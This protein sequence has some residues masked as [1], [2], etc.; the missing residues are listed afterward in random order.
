MACR[1]TARQ[2]A[3]PPWTARRR[4]AVLWGTGRVASAPKV[5]WAWRVPHS[6][7]GWT[8]W[9]GSLS[10]LARLA[11]SRAAACALTD[12]APPAGKKRG[13]TFWLPPALPCGDCGKVGGSTQAP[14]PLRGPRGSARARYFRLCPRTC[15]LARYTRSEALSASPRMD[16]GRALL[17]A[18][19]RVPG[20]PTSAYR[21][22]RLP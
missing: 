18:P 2:F 20:R 4:L 16:A 17:L 9:P 1:S 8:D 13:L 6:L 10:D 12:W 14:P 15:A 7:Y 19:E 11:P 21:G 5:A 22:D 3:A